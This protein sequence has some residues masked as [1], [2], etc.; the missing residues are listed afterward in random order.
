MNRPT[1]VTVLAVLQFI[2][3]ACFVIG[4]L[5]LMVGGTFVAAMLGNAARGGGGTAMAG[6]GAL[7]GVVGGVFCLMF[8]ALHGVVGWGMWNLKNWARMVTLVLAGI[9]ALLQVMGMMGSLLHFHIGL[10]LWHVIWLGVDAV[11]I[12]YLL[13]PEVK[14]AFEGTQPQLRAAGI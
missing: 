9:G 7:I 4:A 5:L 14:A 6:M 2:G 8:A 10:M 3:A 11:I 13:T 1:G 12:W